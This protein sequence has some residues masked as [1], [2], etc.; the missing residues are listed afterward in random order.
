MALASRRS[1]FTLIELLVVIAIIALLVSILVP[2]LQRARA[3]ARSVQCMTIQKRVGIA[4]FLYA[5]DHDGWCQ[6][7]RYAPLPGI[8]TAMGPNVLMGLGYLPKST[9]FPGDF[10]NDNTVYAT[11]CPEYGQYPG[12]TSYGVTTGGYGLNMALTYVYVKPVAATEYTVYWPWN[13][14]ARRHRLLGEIPQPGQLFFWGDF[15]GAGNVGG[16]YFGH[17]AAAGETIGFFYRHMDGVNL[18]F[19]DGHTSYYDGGAID[20]GSHDVEF[21]PWP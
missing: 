11:P 8:G 12:E 2:S 17:E 13:D 20:A 14:P 18:T 10:W 7:A 4:T 16:W 15:S 21:Y 19:A 5:E 6:A 1:G 3:I 9:W